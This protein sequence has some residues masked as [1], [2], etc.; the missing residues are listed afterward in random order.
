MG[1]VSI[2]V[3]L[4]VAL[5]AAV[6]DLRDRRIPNWLTLCG[7]SISLIL[8]L[9]SDGLRRTDGGQQI[10]SVVADVSLTQSVLGLVVVGIFPLALYAANSG[11]AGDVKLAW[12]I[13]AALGIGQ[14]IPA[15]LSAYVLASAWG[16]VWLTLTGR[17][18]TVIYVTLQSFGHCLLPRR[19]GSPAAQDWAMVSDKVAMAPFMMAGILIALMSG[20]P[21]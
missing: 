1:C 20:S 14:G 12:V 11:G 18:G 19:V 15:I 16:L 10:A 9:I 5:V 2:F 17:L 21:T 8:S 13:G 7:V 3:V 6:E 4:A